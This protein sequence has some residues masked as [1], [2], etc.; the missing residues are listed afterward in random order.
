MRSFHHY[1]LALRAH[2][3]FFDQNVSIYF[4]HPYLSRLN[5]HKIKKVIHTTKRSGVKQETSTCVRQSGAKPGRNF[6]LLHTIS[7]DVISACLIFFDWLKW[8]QFILHWLSGRLLYENI[9]PIYFITAI[10]LM[11]FLDPNI[12]KKSQ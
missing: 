1:V 8:F 9:W 5:C 3:T 11:L 10:W 2:M 4:F 12:A 6:N 7:T